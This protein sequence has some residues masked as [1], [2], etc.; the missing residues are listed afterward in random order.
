MESGSR[1][2]KTQRVGHEGR[3][4]VAVQVFTEKVQFAIAGPQDLHADIGSDEG[5][6]MG[7][8]QARQQ[9]PNCGHI[10]IIGDIVESANM[11]IRRPRTNGVPWAR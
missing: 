9:N 8:S 7:L 11:V 3:G 1:R 2:R 6:G 4:G 5:G 10:D